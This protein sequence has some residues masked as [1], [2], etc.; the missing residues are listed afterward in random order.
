M[1]KSSGRLRESYSYE[2]ERGKIKQTLICFGQFSVHSLHTERRS[3][4]GGG[5]KRSVPVLV[6]TRE[7][8]DIVTSGNRLQGLDFARKPC[9][10]FHMLM[11][12]EY[13]VT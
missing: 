1:R 5:R 10:R 4:S 2:A 12:R 9:F 13:A 11:K 7:L 6:R 8:I 3:I